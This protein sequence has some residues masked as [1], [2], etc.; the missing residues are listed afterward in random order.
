MSNSNVQ[1]SQFLYQIDIKKLKN[2]Q[3]LSM[4]FSTDRRVVA[5]F[6]ENGCGKSTVL[7]TLACVFQRL[8]PI[9][10]VE[11][12][13]EYKFTDFFPPTNYGEWNDSE[14]EI[15][16]DEEG[17]Q[18]SRIY[19]KTDRWTRY[20]RR[21]KREIH[22][23]GIDLCVP[24]IERESKKSKIEIQAD[25][26][27]LKSRI[28]KDVSYV[29]NR[30]YESVEFCNNKKY[31]LAKSNNIKYPSLFMGA[32]ENKIIEILS[33]IHNA[34][35]NALILIDELDLTLHT[36]ALK[37]L[38][39][40]IIKIA[41]EKELQVIFTSHREDITNYQVVADNIDIKYITNSLDENQTLCLPNINSEGFIRLTGETQKNRI[42]Y[43]EDIVSKEIVTRFLQKNNMIGDSE[44]VIYGA[45]DNAFTIACGLFLS[46][47]PN[48]E[49]SFFILDGDKYQT[50]NEK[51]EQIKR[52]MGGTETGIEAKWHEILQRILQYNGMNENQNSVSPER[53]IYDTV[54]SISEDC[55]AKK[56]LQRIGYVNDNH[57][58]IPNTDIERRTI[59][60]KFSETDNWVI[61]TQE[62]TLKLVDVE[63][64]SEEKQ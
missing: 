53:Y 4:S 21:P 25:A 5:I 30:N 40:V 62:L 27:I 44:I 18:K 63:N 11:I 61:Y 39:E 35:K 45:I 36:Y 50:E 57:K 28:L 55:E 8:S 20:D 10:D 24:P 23:L 51:L 59:I 60:E 56:I 42:I 48:F 58:L 49:K 17:H 3:N 14:L 16:Y 22:F 6:G 46:N 32:G 37:K 12:G 19:K 33:V 29:M 31:K 2:I 41:N 43:V 34:R 52:K 9:N 64:N 26:D 54:K 15:S 1:G 7:H 47:Q 38:L 13:E